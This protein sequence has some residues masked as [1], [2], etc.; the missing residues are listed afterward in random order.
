MSRRLFGTDGV[1]G[2]ANREP[3]TAGT[4][5]CLA[6]AAACLFRRGE[7]RHSVVVARDTR[8][9]GAML[10]SA[11]TAG[12]TAMGL[13]VIL[14][15]A[16]PTPAV[17]Q[18][19]RSLRAD[20]GVMISASHN[21][22]P[23]NGIKFFGPHGFKLTDEEEAAIEARMA[24]PFDDA[25]AAPAGIGRVER[26]EDAGGRYIE[27]VKASFP[28][29]LS[30]SG[31]RLVVDCAHGAAYRVAP[32]V[33]WE[34]GAEVIPIGVDPTGLNINEKL[35]A[36]HPEA[37]QAAVRD[38]GAD[39]GIALD[40]DADRLFLADEQ[41]RAVDGDQ[42]MALIGASLAEQGRLRGGGVVSTVMS[43]MGL[44]RY[45][46]GRGLGLV[47]T[48]VGDRYVVEHMRRHGFNVGG[49]Q[50]G[51][52][53]LMDHG[54]TGDGL[55]AALQVLAEIQRRQRPA[56]EVLRRFDTV[57]QLQRTVRFD[58]DRGRPALDGAAVTEAVRAAEA[59]LGSTGRVLIRPSGTEPVIRV[60]VEGDDADQVRHLADGIA[61]VIAR[62]A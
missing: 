44:E 46:N 51:H 58:P 52:I 16:L 24:A 34:L 50:S 60:M 22:Y 37:V 45:L 42:I 55:L 38:H 35:G 27:Q 56:S 1:R 5:L 2:T 15:G 32:R 41:G 36:T 20:L 47:R 61:A 43:N 29:E 14:A 11:L 18:L 40:G 31:L 25:L 48:A 30:L 8:L 53:V 59:A 17:A 3:V 10:E 9:S 23:D 54:T 7:H 26:M 6:Q 33:L 4:A 21:P 13:D 19:T 49:E 39:I 28:A 62:S 57:P 12:F